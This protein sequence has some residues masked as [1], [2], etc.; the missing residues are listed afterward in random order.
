MPYP[1]HDMSPAATAMIAV[2]IK[3]S[4]MAFFLISLSLVILLAFF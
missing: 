4:V 3:S 2:V 1:M